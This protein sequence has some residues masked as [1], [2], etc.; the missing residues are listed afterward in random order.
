[1]AKTATPATTD[2][3]ELQL[4][5]EKATRQFVLKVGEHR[6]RIEYDHQGDRI[7]L[8][9]TDVPRPANFFGAALEVEPSTTITKRNVAIASKRNADSML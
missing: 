1:M 3:S 9:R 6:A 8:T 2:L 7:F 4:T 5:D